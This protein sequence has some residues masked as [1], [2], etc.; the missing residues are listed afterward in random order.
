M[1]YA[2]GKITERLERVTFLADGEVPSGVREEL[3]RFELP[4]THVKNSIFAIKI[5]YKKKSNHIPGKQMSH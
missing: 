3:A 5:S 4:I 2:S 1:G